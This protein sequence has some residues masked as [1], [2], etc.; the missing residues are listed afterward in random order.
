[1]LTLALSRLQPCTDPVLLVAAELEEAVRNHLETNSIEALPEIWPVAGQ[2]ASEAVLE[3]ADRIQKVPDQ[4]VVLQ[5]WCWPL[6]SETG[7]QRLTAH[8]AES[9]TPAQ[10]VVPRWPQFAQWRQKGKRPTLR[11]LISQGTWGME[12]AQLLRWA[13][14]APEAENWQELTARHPD[15]WA[16]IPGHS[17]N[18]DM[19]VGRNRDL[20][21]LLLSQ[22]ILNFGM[23]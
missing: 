16:F 10:I 14:A 3:V 19:R 18:L 22:Q 11:Q 15:D 20:L 17:A 5:S 7:L 6:V 4:P 13:E 23:L 9:R 12:I 1:L 8:L 21:A 2:T